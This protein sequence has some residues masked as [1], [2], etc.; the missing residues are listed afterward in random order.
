MT[1]QINYARLWLV[2]TLWLK[3]TKF[4]PLCL[5]VLEVLEIEH[6]IGLKCNPFTRSFNFMCVTMQ[7]DVNGMINE[8]TDQPQVFPVQYAGQTAMYWD[9]FLLHFFR[10]FSV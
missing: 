4:L 10:G 6:F 2:Q 1:P 5:E 7:V 3:I 8:A 9:F